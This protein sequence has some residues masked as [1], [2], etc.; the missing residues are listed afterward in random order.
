MSTQRRVVET[1]DPHAAWAAALGDRLLDLVGD[2]ADVAGVAPAGDDEV[3]ADGEHV[4][5]LEDHGSVACFSAAARA[6]TTGQSARVQTVVLA[7]SSLTGSARSAPDDDGDV[8]GV[9]AERRRGDRRRSPSAACMRSAGSRGDQ[10]VVP[11]VGSSVREP[12]GVADGDHLGAGDDE[13]LDDRP[14]TAS[15]VAGAVE[16][17]DPDPRARGSPPSAAG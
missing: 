10:V 2:G 11:H 7:P 8:E 14:A 5:D 6:A 13:R 15:G 9:G 16:D 1:L 3:V 4:A 12:V 17:P